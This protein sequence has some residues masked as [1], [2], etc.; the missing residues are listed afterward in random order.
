MLR[1]AEEFRREAQRPRKKKAKAKK[2]KRPSA[3]TSLPGVS[4]TAKKRG[5]GHTEPRNES[6]HADRKA[7]FALEDSATGH[8]S[9]KSTR[10]SSNRIKPDAGLKRRQT[11]RA[12]SAT[13]RARRGK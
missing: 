2:P 6:R 3:D 5:L 4:A 9:R 7:S 11:S 8:P 1:K 10:K 13:T 12:T